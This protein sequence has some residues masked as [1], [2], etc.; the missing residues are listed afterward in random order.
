[1]HDSASSYL[2]CGRRRAEKGYDAVPDPGIHS[3]DDRRTGARVGP[4][5]VNIGNVTPP[6]LCRFY[7]C[8]AS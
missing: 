5:I 2:M 8:V 4:S 6:G 3:G 7:I 1:M